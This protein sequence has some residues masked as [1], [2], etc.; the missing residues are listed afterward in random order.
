MS[1]PC[2]RPRRAGAA[3]CRSARP[4]IAVIS[5]NYF[6]WSHA[7][8]CRGPGRACGRG[9]GPWA[10]R[11]A[12]VESRA[13]SGLVRRRCSPC[14][15]LL[16]PGLP[17]SPAPAPV[18]VSAAGTCKAPWR[19]AR[20]LFGA[21]LLLLEMCPG[22][23]PPPST[24]RSPSLPPPQLI[25]AWGINGEILLQLRCLIVTEPRGTAG[26]PTAAWRGR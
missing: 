6:L 10:R 26:C 5:I 17:R 15:Y 2:L 11:G 14:P 7:R 3:L 12:A 18:H 25:A 20:L 19:S 1:W 4:C 21:T 13:P 22:A 9:R 23:S 24:P 16:S 8:G